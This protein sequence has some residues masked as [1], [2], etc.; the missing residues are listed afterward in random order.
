MAQV[1]FEYNNFVN[2]STRKTPFEIFT[3][4]QPRGISYLRDVAGEE[5][6]RVEGEDFSDFMKYF[7]EEVKLKLEQ[8]N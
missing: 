4:I 8:S 2:R 6:R 1:G 5:K 3:G 7:H